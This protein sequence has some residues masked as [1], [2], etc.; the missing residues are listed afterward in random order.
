MI[1]YIFLAIAVCWSLLPALAAGPRYVFLMIGDGMGINQVAAT[2]RFLAAAEDGRIGREPLTMATFPYSALCHTY[3]LSNG[4]TDSSAAGTAL[5]TGHK[6]SNGTL[7]MDSAHAVAYPSVAELARRAGRA[8]GI[9]TSVSIDHATPGAFYA[10]VPSRKHYY[11]IGRQMAASGFDFFGGA[12]FLAP[13][14]KKHDRPH[15]HDVLA[16]SGY[17]VVKG[18]EAYLTD[19]AQA[20]RMFLTQA[21]GRG[22]RRLE[23]GRSSLP[24]AIDRDSADLTL[25]RMTAAAIDFLSKKDSGFFLMVEGGA[26][27]W[28]CHSN[29]AATAFAEVVDFDS[30][31]AL[32]YDFYLR[33]PDE[34]LIVVT[35]DHETGGLA[36][37][38]KDYRLRF[39]L[40]RGQQ[41]SQPELSKAVAALFASHGNAP[42]WD[43]VKALLSDRL[44]L[45]S[46]LKLS[47]A[48]EAALHE[49]FEKSLAGASATVDNEY[50]EDHPLAVA[51]VRLLNRLSRCGWT[52][53][54]HSGAPVAVYAVGVGAERFTG[55]LDNT[56][57]PRRIV[58]LA[59]Y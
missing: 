59:E 42:G 19:S 5:S 56:E 40:I 58:S 2:E 12:D 44:G 46:V 35:A 22:N 4:V 41:C 27:D 48:D 53:G 39:D 8:V 18:L 28:A 23:R 55:V 17:T 1:R 54:A 57:I 24:F 33:H 3:S 32:A 38:N 7:G 21:D 49:E 10:H 9:V 52:T 15:L 14:G 43:D 30:A 36:M 20:R 47:E 6:T 26:I 37:G 11:E 45:F 31:V 29:D 34:T 16:D 51:A 50:A 13:T 25:P